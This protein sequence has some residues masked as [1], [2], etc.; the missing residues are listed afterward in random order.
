MR[1]SAWV[2]GSSWGHGDV[3]GVFVD[4]DKRTLFYYKNGVCAPKP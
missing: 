4:I 1:G 2:E 3:I